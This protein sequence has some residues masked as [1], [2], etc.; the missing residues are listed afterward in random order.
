MNPDAASTP[1]AGRREAAPG[2]LAER[3]LMP[4]LFLVML[5]VVLITS[6]SY[7]HTRSTAEELALG[8]MSQTLF[9]IEKEMGAKI[10]RLRVDATLWSR[11]DVFRLS[12]GE[13]YLARSAR[14]AS[15][16]RLEERC[17]YNN[18]DRAFI[19][20]DDGGVVAASDPGMVGTIN[21][22]DRRYFGE[23]LHG[24][25]AFETLEAGKYTGE[26]VLVVSAPLLVTGE[27]VSGAL[28]LVADLKR[29]ALDIIEGGR[30]GRTGGAYVLGR[31]NAVVAA[32]SWKGPGMFSPS[33]GTAGI[34]RELGPGEVIHHMSGET[35]RLAMAVTVPDT[36]WLLVVEADKAEI[37]LPAARLA[38]LNA[39]ISLAVLALVA[40]VLWV[41]RKAVL[42]L[43]ASEV[44]YR[45]LAETAPLG[46][47]TFDRFGKAGYM[48][49]RAMDILGIGSPGE[50]S[51]RWAGAFEDRDGA[52]M[53]FDGLPMA[54]A[55][56]ELRPVLGRTVVYRRGDARLILSLSA[57]PLGAKPGA[58]A[59]VVCAIEDISERVRIQ[60]MM[61]QTEKMLS[62]GG[63][64]AGM[65]HEINNPLASILQAVQVIERRLA[66]DLPAN[67]ETAGRL[68]LD[69]KL[70]QAYMRER[71]LEPFIRGINEAGV[72]A[73]RI[74]KNM[75][76]FAR[77][78]G[79]ESAPWDLGE[80]L[81][82]TVELAGG[83]YD[84]KKQYDF[85]RI[86]IVREYDPGLGP[87]E[88]Q[89]TEMEQVFFN[90]IKNAAQAL[91]DG[92]RD[93]DRPRITLRTR[94][95]EGMALVEIE[96]NGPG[97]AGEVSGR[98]FE[99]F[100]T[101]KEVGSGTGL[102]LSVA[103]FIVSENHGG[104]ITLDSSPGKGS[105]FSVWLPMRR[106]PGQA[107]G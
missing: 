3:Y 96:D 21:I 47:A 66:P 19:A 86:E 48:N 63:L 68:G 103:Y 64:A 77:K 34:M 11:E 54:Q 102:G 17:Q 26:P 83:D 42:G 10:R 2:P 94:R 33:A 73:A 9:F 55:M 27:N 30:M 95:S 62:V 37:L 32:P 97:M 44:R 38:A 70:V 12:L 20:A 80:L 13:G 31:D 105:K 90:I 25:V 81:D 100:Y 84:L 1:P 71:G 85:K 88:C 57:A 53:A 15:N 69:L 35:E 91:K 87:V 16:R 51:G 82:K 40:A 74:V 23:T 22:R 79:G 101:T 75:L 28:V 76:G 106:P 58:V 59:G 67:L 43:R 24:N 60:E 93:G 50:D 4:V 98:V 78:S 6:F 52:P 36:G 49:R 41:L 45:T 89:G 14:T 107:G 61:V 18:Y 29:F 72:R 5:G 92:V 46:I 65:A 39:A 7:Y 104:R 8:Q 99:P 56:R